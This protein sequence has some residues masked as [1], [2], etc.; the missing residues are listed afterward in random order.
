MSQ[1][2][3]FN[4][5][6][7]PRV[8][9]HWANT[10]SFLP[11]LIICHGLVS[12]GCVFFLTIGLLGR[13]TQCKR[14]QLVLSLWLWW[15]SSESTTEDWALFVLRTFIFLSVITIKRK[16]Q[17]QRKHK[18]HKWPKRYSCKQ[19]YQENNT[20]T[21]RGP[22][23]AINFCEN[24]GEGSSFGAL[25]KK[26]FISK[27][28]VSECSGLCKEA[29]DGCGRSFEIRKR[30]AES[31]GGHSRYSWDDGGGHHQPAGGCRFENG[32]LGGHGMCT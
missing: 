13:E 9:W 8:P 1:S 6:A 20:T 7:L 24:G 21:A 30:L 5:R 25:R 10:F 31:G 22:S 23:Y 12:F 3:C 2:S 28:K 14:N 4:C 16:C 18:W 15:L 29:Q 32:R 27:W 17:L 26:V 19:H 11:C